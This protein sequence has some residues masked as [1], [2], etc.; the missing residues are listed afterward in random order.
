MTSRRWVKLKPALRIEAANSDIY[1]T[2][3]DHT[4]TAAGNTIGNAAIEN[5]SNYNGLMILGRT[6]AAG[7]LVRLWDRVGIGGNTTSGLRCAARREGRDQRGAVAF[8]R[9]SAWSQGQGRKTK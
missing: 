9:I 6:T 2:K 1:F 8:R 4:F 7:R 3:P 5:S